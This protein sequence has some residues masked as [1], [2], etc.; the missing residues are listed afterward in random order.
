[1]PYVAPLWPAGHLPRKGGDWLLCLISPA[2]QRCGVVR[3]VETADLPLVGEMAGRPEGVRE[4][5]AVLSRFIFAL[6]ANDHERPCLNA[7]WK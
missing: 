6:E 5:L 2:L 1:M 3:D 4:A 7:P